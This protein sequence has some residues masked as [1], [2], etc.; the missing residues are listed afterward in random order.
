MNQNLPPPLTAEEIAHNRQAW[1][2]TKLQIQRDALRPR[3]PEPPPDAPTCPYHTEYL[4]DDGGCCLC[5]EE[6][7]NPMAYQ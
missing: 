2:I 7:G 4:D 6:F 1:E 5:D 3:P